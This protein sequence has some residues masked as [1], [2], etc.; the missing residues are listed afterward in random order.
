MS[1]RFESRSVISG[2]GI[3]QVGRKTGL[4]GIAMTVSAARAAIADAGLVPSDI[5]GLATVGD[6]SRAAVQDALGLQ[7]GW[8]ATVNS[9]EDGNTGRRPNSG[10]SSTLWRFPAA[11]STMSWSTGQFR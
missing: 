6:T 11:W 9:A 5:D 4:T 7:L 8:G 3:S 1:E 2:I 10:P